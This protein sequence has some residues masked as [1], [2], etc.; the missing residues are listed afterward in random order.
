MAFGMTT[1]HIH[2]TRHVLCHLYKEDFIMATWKNLDTLASYGELSKLKNHVDIAKAMS[3]ENGA[4]RVAKYSVPMA[5]GLNYNYHDRF[6]HRS[7]GAV[8][9]AGHT[10]LLCGRDRNVRRLHRLLHLLHAAGKA[11]A[12]DGRRG[13]PLRHGR[14]RCPGG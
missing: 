2:T 8:E 3:G 9:I 14:I 10:V 7:G 6:R 12:G 11:P 4:E 13:A 1:K 5:A